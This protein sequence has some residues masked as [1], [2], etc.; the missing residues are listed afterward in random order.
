MIPARVDP[1]YY[2]CFDPNKRLI[3]MN[4]SYVDD[5]L[6]AGN[7]KLKKLCQITQRKSETTPGEEL[8]FS[9]AEL[10]LRQLPDDSYTLDQSFYLEKIKILSDDG[11]WSVFAS[12]RMMLAWLENS[13]PDLCVEMSQIASVTKEKI[14][15]NAKKCIKHLNNAITYAHKYPTQL[16]YPKLDISKVRIVGYRDAAFANND[17]LSSQLG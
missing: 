2:L 9:L 6:R 1:V 13:R 16:R 10:E 14:S 15:E 12:R 17:D 7:S 11:P 3:G 8:P 5:L 4:G